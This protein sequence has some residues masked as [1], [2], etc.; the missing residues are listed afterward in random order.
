MEGK[1]GSALIQRRLKLRSSSGC[2]DLGR[3]FVEVGVCLLRMA[4]RATGTAGL[5]AGAQGIV[6]DLPNGA[7]TAAALRAAAQTAVYLIGCARN[8]IPSG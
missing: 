1:P 5:R 7:S 6:H 2:V 8:G 4:V 3:I